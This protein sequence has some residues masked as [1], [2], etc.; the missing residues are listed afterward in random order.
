[1]SGGTL[2]GECSE[3]VSEVPERSSR[4]PSELT[5]C[6]L[7]VAGDLQDSQDIKGSTDSLGLRTS[8]GG[9]RLVVGLGGGARDMVSSMMPHDAWQEGQDPFFLYPPSH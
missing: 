7:T 1:M 3:R 6:S 2:P 4:G 8:L 5:G 9:G